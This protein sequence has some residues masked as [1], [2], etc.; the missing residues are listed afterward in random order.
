METPKEIPSIHNNERNTTT[1]ISLID[2]E[3]RKKLDFKRQSKVIQNS[4]KINKS[5][6]KN[7]RPTK[8][9]SAK[10]QSNARNSQSSSKSNRNSNSKKR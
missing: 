6:D 2:K 8:I 3:R 10:N 1:F 5:K 7:S 4:P 9:S